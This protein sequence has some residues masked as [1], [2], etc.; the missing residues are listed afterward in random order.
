MYAAPASITM[1]RTETGA[2]MKQVIGLDS[3][4]R[5]EAEAFIRAIY[6]RH[7]DAHVACFAP[8][9]F[10]LERT[11]QDTKTRKILAAAGWRCAAKG[12]LFLETYLDHPVHVHV[13]GLAG[14]PVAREH[15]VEVGHLASSSP[16][17]GARMILALAG[18]LDNLGY[19]WVVFTATRELI[20]IFTRL[21]LPPLALSIA[22]PA[23]L[24]PAARAWGR[25][26][27]SKP[28]VV[29]GR[30]RLA[31]DRMRKQPEPTYA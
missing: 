26:Y 8:D 4:R 23:R 9:L 29:A 1:H 20:A 31:V 10:L 14:Q 13:S 24:G 6:A 11:G 2:D 16:G 28:V 3:P 7:H 30:I 15:I 17:G 19:E 27:D 25:Y 22:D 12:S 18:H 21:G 5:E